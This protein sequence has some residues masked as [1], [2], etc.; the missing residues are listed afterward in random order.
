MQINVALLFARN[1]G[2]AGALE[3]GDRQ[4][5]KDIIAREYLSSTGSILSYKHWIYSGNKE[6]E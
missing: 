1:N 3:R 5:K 6:W 2:Q 4:P